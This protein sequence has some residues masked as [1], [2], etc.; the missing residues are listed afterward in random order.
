MTRRRAIVLL[1]ALVLPR[2]VTAATQQ[3]R[4]RRIGFLAV[5]S[6]PT[7]ANPDHY[8]AF[9]RGMRE[10][11]YIEGQ[12]LAIEWRFADANLERLP[13][14]A[15]DLVR[16]NVEV[17]VTHSTQGTLAAQR[18]TST[19]PIVTASA[20]DPVGSG[21][22]AS[23]ARPGGKI[24]GLAVITGD[25]N[26]KHLELLTTI[27]PNLS[28]VAVLVDPDNPSHGAT[29]KSLR[30]AAEKAKLTA[31]PVEARG[32]PEDLERAF[33]TAKAERAEGMVVQS[34]P[35]FIAERRRITDLASK[36][37][38]P[39]IFPYGDYVEAGG[40]ISYGQ[41]LE[42]FYRRAASYVDKILKGANP[43]DLP[44]EQPTKF[45]LLV[46]LRTAKALG[47]AIPPAILL[48]ADKVIQ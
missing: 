46:N 19:I 29:L 1:G 10:L 11:G 20:T 30:M 43:A 25:V 31:F 17:L 33:A 36:H 9:V 28:R 41:N 32:R 44:F 24:T 4:L 42:V 6:R 35:F 2:S 8:D 26:P 12:N 47:I 45:D 5:R 34:G 48:Q 16:A 38:L 3:M 21:F 22:A 7:A 27:V 40:L 39:S 37:R 14:L 18:A 23:L 13:V 15:A